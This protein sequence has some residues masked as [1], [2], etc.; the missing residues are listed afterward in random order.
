MFSHI[1]SISVNSDQEELGIGSS[2]Q[3]TDILSLSQ[4]A[5]E[6][7]ENNTLDLEQAKIRTEVWQHFDKSPDHLANKSVTC[8]YCFKTFTSNARSTGNNCEDIKMFCYW[9]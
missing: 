9:S 8:K 5:D 6:S 1:S 4:I 3:S 2:S 7:V